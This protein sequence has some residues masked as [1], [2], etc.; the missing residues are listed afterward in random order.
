MERDT[1]DLSLQDRRD[2]LADLL[3]LLLAEH[4]LQRR[5]AAIEPGN[6]TTIPQTREATLLRSRAIDRKS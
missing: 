6:S 2:E 1:P 5:R 3:G 4:W